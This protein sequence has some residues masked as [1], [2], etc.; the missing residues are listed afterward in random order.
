LVH[1]GLQ[2]E[3]HAGIVGPIAFDEQD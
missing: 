3:C 1:Q 2:I